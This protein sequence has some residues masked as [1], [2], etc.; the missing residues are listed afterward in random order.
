MTTLPILALV[1][2]GVLGLFFY[3]YLFIFISGPNRARAFGRIY[4]EIVSPGPNGER[5]FIKSI[6]N[7]GFFKRSFKSFL[8]HYRLMLFPVPK[9]V[10]GKACPDAHLVTLSGESKSLLKDYVKVN[11]EMPLILNMGSYT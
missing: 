10:A 11:N 8:R 3:I 2:T 5:P 7:W 1:L 6:T 4:G 9:A